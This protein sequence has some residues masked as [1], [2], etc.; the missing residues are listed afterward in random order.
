MNLFKKYILSKKTNSHISKKA[1]LNKN[2]IL[3]G[4]NY[5]GDASVLNTHLGKGSYIGSGSIDNTII[6]KYC[7]IGFNVSVIASTH[8]KSFVSTSPKFFNNKGTKFENDIVFNE[9]LTTKEG[10]FCEIG[11][12]VWVG[13]N[14]IIIGGLKIGDGVIIGAGSVVTKPL[15]PYKISAGVPAREIGSRFSK[16]ITDELINIKWWDLEDKEIQKLMFYNDDVE[17]FIEEYKRIKATLK[18]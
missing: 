14:V 3:D 13:N 8:P 17:H 5:I 12:D 15:E 10:Y 2:T 4:L 9:Y 6:G 7:S 16:S 18:N 1:R 11:N